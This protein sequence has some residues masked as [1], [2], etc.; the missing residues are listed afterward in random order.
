MNQ[1]LNFVLVIGV[2]LVG[3]DF[4]VRAMGPR[5]HATWRRGLRRVGVSLRR[6]VVRLVR[7]IWRQTF[8]FLR[9]AWRNYWR[10]IVGGAIGLTLGIILSIRHFTGRFP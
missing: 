9:W 3:F 1:L 7:W 6:Q 10:F 4:I 8:R 5:T 2:M